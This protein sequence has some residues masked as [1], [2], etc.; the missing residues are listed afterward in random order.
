MNGEVLITDEGLREFRARCMLARNT[1]LAGLCSDA[2]A[3][4]GAARRRVAAIASGKPDPGAPTI[5]PDGLRAALRDAD[6]A[7]ITRAPLLETRAV[8]RNLRDAVRR[9]DQAAVATGPERLTSGQT[10]DEAYAAERADYEP[11]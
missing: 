11:D 5:L 1:P 9:Y 3:G 2:L 10:P 6:E 7:L 4:D 8:L